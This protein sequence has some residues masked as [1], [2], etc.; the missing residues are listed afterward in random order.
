MSIDFAP[1]SVTEADASPSAASVVKLGAHIGARIDGV[2]LGGHLDPAT[3]S[4]IRQA[5]LDHKVIFFRG[6]DHLTD[7]SQYEFAELLGSPTTAHPTVTSRGTK[8]LPIDSDYGKANSWHT[9]VTFVDRIPKA[10]ILRAVK[11][12]TYGGST[13]WASGVAAYNALPEPLKVLADNLWA[14]HTNVYDYAATSAERAQDEKATEYRAEFQS[15]Y[16]ETEH[17]VVRVHPE[18]GERTL[19][20][21]HFIKSLVGLS[22][23][24]SQALFRVLQDHAISLE[25]TTRWNWQDGDVA[26]WDNRATQHYAVA[27]YDDQYRRLNRITLAGDVPVDIRGERSRSIAGDAS[28]YSVVDEP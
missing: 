21:G 22:S 18:T 1:E 28:G 24:Q 13:T 23:T 12:P 15:T 10:S 2:R 25:F 5:L 4:L 26:I 11:L 8:I 9:D 27:D 7:D 16:F 19:L 6:Q 3:V 20:L 17:P 14:T